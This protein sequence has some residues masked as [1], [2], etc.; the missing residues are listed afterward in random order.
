MPT[1][2]YY[3]EHREELLRK[4]KEYDSKHKERI[5]LYFRE[6]YAK[7]GVNRAIDYQDAIL[8]W[9][10]KNPEKKNAHVKLNNAIRDGKVIKPISC[11]KCNRNTRISGH[12]N[13]YSK[14]LEVIWLCSSCHKLLHAKM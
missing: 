10:R 13:D 6:W 12:H 1:K 2:A 14:P 5:R 9:Q 7:N 3:A 11:Q 4:K 8:E